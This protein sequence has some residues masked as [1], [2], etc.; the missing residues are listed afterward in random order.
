MTIHEAPELDKEVAVVL[1]GQLQEPLP[2]TQGFRVY[3]N[4][5]RFE[6]RDHTSH[7]GTKQRALKALQRE[8][9]NRYATKINPFYREHIAG[10]IFSDS[11]ENKKYDKLRESIYR[12]KDI[13]KDLIN[14]KV[15]TIV[16]ETIPR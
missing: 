7:W 5:R 8:L 15:I 9:Y 16:E 11:P 3:I 2:P 6:L 4:G 10:K 13:I 1:L 12:Y 14:D